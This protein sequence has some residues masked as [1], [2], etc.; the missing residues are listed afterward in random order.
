MYG[1]KVLERRSASSSW[2][3]MSATLKRHQMLKHATGGAHRRCPGGAKSKPDACHVRRVV[4]R[5]L[6]PL[7][8]TSLD[9]E[10]GCGNCIV[11]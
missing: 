8:S 3:V 7:R 4:T 9:F 5:P 2:A 11:L 6:Q 10:T 1:A